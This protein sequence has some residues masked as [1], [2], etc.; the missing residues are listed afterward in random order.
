MGKEVFSPRVEEL[1][2]L[3]GKRDEPV[4]KTDDGGG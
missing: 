1:G 4:K 3:E 2:E